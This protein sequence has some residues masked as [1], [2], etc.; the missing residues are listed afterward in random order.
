MF[1]NLDPI[2]LR[3]AGDYTPIP[4]NGAGG[5]VSISI[6]PFFGGQTGIYEI[7]IYNGD[8]SDPGFVEQRRVSLAPYTRFESFQVP[9][10]LSNPQLGL[11]LIQ[12]A[13]LGTYDETITAQF[14]MPP[15]VEA[16]AS[17]LPTTEWSFIDQLP[18]GI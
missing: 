7:G 2:Q 14:H 13:D 18:A 3:S 12:K 5:V 17:D 6:P 11:R 9:P 16:E 4:L 15:T 1:Q 8:D 10:S